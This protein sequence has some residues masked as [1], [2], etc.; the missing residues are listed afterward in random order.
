MTIEIKNKRTGDVLLRVDADDLR[1]AFLRDAN[2]YYANLYY[3]DLRDA[4]LR[5]ANLAAADLRGADLR[6]AD[7]RWANLIGANLRWAKL[8]DTDLSGTCVVPL[9]QE[10][11]RSYRLV[12]HE[13]RYISG[14]RSFTAEQALEHW[15]APDYP[16]PERGALYV[17]AIKKHME[18]TA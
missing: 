3:A 13:G 6:G 9:L 5:G 7:L 18:A 11:R 10:M 8:M 14:C 1:G 2:L 4:D 17:A 15:G 16:V 12:W